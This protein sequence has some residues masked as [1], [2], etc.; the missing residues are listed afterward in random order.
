[1]IDNHPDAL[2]QVGLDAT[3]VV[4]EERVEGI[5]RFLAGTN[6]STLSLNAITPN[7]SP[8]CSAAKPSTIAAVM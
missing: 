7:R 5:T 6:E 8:C 3:D 1:M 2:P 4:F